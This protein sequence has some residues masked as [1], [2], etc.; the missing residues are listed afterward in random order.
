MLSK[1]KYSVSGSLLHTLCKLQQDGMLIS[2]NGFSQLSFIQILHSLTS[3]T[4]THQRYNRLQIK[5]AKNYPMAHLFIL[6]N[7]HLWQE[8][9]TSALV[10]LIL[11]NCMARFLRKQSKRLLRHFAWHYFHVNT[12]NSYFGTS[13]ASLAIL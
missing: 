12:M 9:V 3:N 8:T 6:N 5:Q 2:I 10:R 4:R 13:P 7:F 1:C 11:K